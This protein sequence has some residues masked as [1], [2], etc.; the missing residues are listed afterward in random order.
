MFSL[1]QSAM[2]TEK[3][4]KTNKY[5]SQFGV[6]F[7]NDQEESIKEDSWNQ[8]KADL[9]RNIISFHNYSKVAVFRPEGNF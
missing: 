2:K 5:L 3:L 9:L 7:H 6:T 1:R 8:K 4:Q